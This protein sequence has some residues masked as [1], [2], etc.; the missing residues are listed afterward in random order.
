MRRRTAAQT[1]CSALQ[2]V[3]HK[4]RGNGEQAE[5]RE[6]VHT[7]IVEVQSLCTF[8]IRDHHSFSKTYASELTCLSMWR[9]GGLRICN[10]SWEAATAERHEDAP[11]RRLDRYD[12]CEILQPTPSEIFTGLGVLL[13][14]ALAFGLVAELLVR[15]PAH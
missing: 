10:L 4:H 1:S 8:Y 13:A 6:E 2:R 9:H 15:L 3:A 11:E 14:I 5:K 7:Q 12:P